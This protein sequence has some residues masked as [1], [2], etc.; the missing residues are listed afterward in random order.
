MMSEGPIVR[1]ADIAAHR[2]AEG[3][4]TR[5]VIENVHV[6]CHI[7]GGITVFPVLKDGGR[8]PAP[9]PCFHCGAEI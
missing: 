8:R 2:L 1:A 6:R 9:A 4:V 3:K 5:Y 7:C